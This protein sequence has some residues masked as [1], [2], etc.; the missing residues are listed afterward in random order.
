MFS[1]WF[2]HKPWFV[3]DM[4]SIC[5]MGSLSKIYKFICM[6]DAVRFL[7]PCMI[8]D[9]AMFIYVVLE[10]RYVKSVLLSFRNGIVWLWDTSTLPCSFRS[11]MYTTYTRR[12]VLGC[13]SSMWSS[14]D[15]SSDWRTDSIGVRAHS[16]TRSLV[17]LGSLLAWSY[18]SYSNQSTVYPCLCTFFLKLA[19]DASSHKSLWSRCVPILLGGGRRSAPCGWAFSTTLSYWSL[20]RI[21]WLVEIPRILWSLWVCS[22]RRKW[23]WNPC[24]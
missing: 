4:I 22:L 5:M 19:I 11:H 23:R 9:I 3:S 18:G 6:K 7:L 21:N 2:W 13:L 10:V 15:F 14:Q 1:Y 16:S 17:F 8:V 20:S 24:D 12:N